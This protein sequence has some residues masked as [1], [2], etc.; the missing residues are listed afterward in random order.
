MQLVE[1]P[2]IVKFPGGLANRS[3]HGFT[4][5]RVEVAALG[6]TQQRRALVGRQ[7][8]Q[9]GSDKRGAR[10][11]TASRDDRGRKGDT[12][13]VSTQRDL[14]Y[15]RQVLVL[16]GSAKGGEPGSTTSAR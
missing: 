4:L 7:F 5:E 12:E 9:R 14:L 1:V 15:V 2:Q 10:V 13:V 11:R 6:Q 16:A 8:E 3:L